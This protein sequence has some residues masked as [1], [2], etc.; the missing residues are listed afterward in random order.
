MTRF[1]IISIVGSIVLTLVV[2]ALPLL[3]PNT[4]AKVQRKLEEKAQQTYRQDSENQP[5]VKVF[6]PWKTML[7]A[8]LVLTILIN[9]FRVLAR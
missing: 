2:N 5:R 4:T 1:L 6:F 8:S 7:V 3:F 9:L